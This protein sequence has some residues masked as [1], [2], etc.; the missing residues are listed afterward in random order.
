MATTT[1]SQLITKSDLV[2]LV[3]KSTGH[4]KVSTEAT[5]NAILE[6]IMAQ[7]VKGNEIRLTGFATISKVKRP[8]RNGVNP[9]T[10]KKIK[11]SAKTTVSIQVG[12][13]FKMAVKASK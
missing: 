3:A 2:D 9:Q 12:R 13:T 6:T 7:V 4:S 11:I 8:A 10:L 5:L 1:T